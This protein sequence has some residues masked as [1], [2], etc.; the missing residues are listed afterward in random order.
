MFRFQ[1]ETETGSETDNILKSLDNSENVSCFALKGG[2]E[3][4]TVPVADDELESIELPPG[5]EVP[6]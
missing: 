6:T 3:G 2:A 1:N 4:D 5:M